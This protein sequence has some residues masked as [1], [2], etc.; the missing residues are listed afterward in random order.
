MTNLEKESS[1]VAIDYKQFLF[2]LFY[3]ETRSHVSQAGFKLA[4]QLRVDQLLILL[5]LLVP[6][7]EAQFIYI[8]CIF[9]SYRYQ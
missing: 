6:A 7:L 1:T 8:S 3:F 4:I 9:L 5:P 2:S